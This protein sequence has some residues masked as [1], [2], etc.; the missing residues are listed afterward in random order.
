MLKILIINLLSVVSVWAQSPTSLV[1]PLNFGLTKEEACLSHN[2]SHNQITIGAVGDL[3]MHGP[4]QKKAVLKGSFAS[5]WGKILKPISDADIMYANLETPTAN[6]INKKWQSNEN[7]EL[8]YDEDTYTSYPMFNAHGQLIKDL[9]QSGFDI[10]S[11]ANNHSLDRGPIGV[12][13]TL[14][15]LRKNNLLYSGSKNK[16]EAKTNWSE[17]VYHNN[18]K[19]AFLSCTFF[20]NVDYDKSKQVLNCQR[21]EKIILAEIENLKSKTDVIIVTPHW[22]EEYQHEPN[23]Q[24]KNFGHKV[25]QAG[26]NLVLGAHPHVIQPFEKVVT[27]DGRESL[28]IY[29]LGNFV[30][31]QSSVAKKSSFLAYITFVKTNNNQVHLGLL[32]YI[33]LMM[34]N[35]YVGL[36]NI[37]VIPLHAGMSK[38]QE[39]LNHIFSILPVENSLKINQTP[40]FE[41]YCN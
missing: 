24:Q 26:A 28:I 13:L 22:G 4:L 16:N 18:W 15:E 35:W 41:K 29:S 6:G 7:T 37:E 25:I 12:D 31:Y 1:K 34:K 23:R 9:K 3:L 14:Q 21:D 32:E 36:E 17:I 33:P 40:G 5:L 2:Q 8:S 38:N 20:L 39:F 10:V 19:V 11:T 27:P 30:S